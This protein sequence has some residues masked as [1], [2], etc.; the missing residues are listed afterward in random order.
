VLS[1]YDFV[2]TSAQVPLFDNTGVYTS[3]LATTFRAPVHLPTGTM[4]KELTVSV[5]ATTTQA[6]TTMKPRYFGSI[7]DAGLGNLGADITFTASPSIQTQ[8]TA[9]EHEVRHGW[10]HLADVRV[11]GGTSSKIVAALIANG[12]LAGGDNRT[13]SVANGRHV[14][15]GAIELP[16]VVPPGARA[17]A[18]NL[19]VANPSLNGFL[20]I[21]PGG[22]AEVT[23]SAINWSTPPPV[24]L[25]NAGIVA[26]DDDR[27]VKVFAGGAG[28][29]TDFILDITGYHI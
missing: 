6:A 8:T 16:D 1:P 17:V 4:V 27:K 14:D 3:L 24:A 2:P 12:R 13:I 19:T 10:Q 25:A 20:A 15:T 21:A 23:A 11:A 26:L 18:D 28:S 29:S 5:L 22:A 9:L 7:I